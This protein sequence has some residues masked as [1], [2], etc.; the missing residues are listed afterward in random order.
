MIKGVALD[1]P[2]AGLADDALEFWSRD[3]LIGLGSCHVVDGLLDHR[4][5]DVIRAEGK[6]YLS[7]L[8][9]DHDPVG[10]EMWDVVENQ[11]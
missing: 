6:S 10:L 2:I 5:V 7:E 8:G 1:G 3:V 11:S 4:A 9:R